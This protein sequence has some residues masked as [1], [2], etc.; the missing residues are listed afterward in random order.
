M[1]F[2]FGLSMGYGRVAR[3]YNKIFGRPSIGTRVCA[4]AFFTYLY[5]SIKKGDKIIDCGCGDGAYSIELA[6]KGYDVTG[7]D[8]EE[9]IE[10]ASYYSK[11]DNINVKFEIGNLLDLPFDDE[12]FDI[13]VCIEVLEHIKDD[14]KVLKEIARVLKDG[15]LLLMTTPSKSER[16]VSLPHEDHVR[17]G[18]SIEELSNQLRKFN[19]VICDYYYFRKFF[20]SY[21]QKFIDSFGDFGTYLMPFMYPLFYPLTYLDKFSK[22]EGNSIVIKIRKV[23]IK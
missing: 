14:N 9:R 5:P 10:Y 4:R 20:S 16:Y 8:F 3:F 2:R 7:I 6:K 18:Y 11:R 17:V 19:L 23:V 22:G 1:M 13:A 15:G 21:I 12:T